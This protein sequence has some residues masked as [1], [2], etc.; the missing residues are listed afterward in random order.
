MECLWVTSDWYTS[1]RYRKKICV[2]LHRSGMGSLHLC[3]L[4]IIPRFAL[5]S[6]QNND[7]VGNW[8]ADT[9]QHFCMS[10]VKEAFMYLE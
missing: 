10:S 6:V 5:L 9:C 2:K 8:T 7:V 3:W 4:Q 1:S